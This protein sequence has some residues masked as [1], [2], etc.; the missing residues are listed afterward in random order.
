MPQVEADFEKLQAELPGADISITSQS[1]DNQARTCAC[2]HV[3][4]WQHA[5]ILYTM[6]GPSV[7]KLTCAC[8]AVTDQRSP[9]GF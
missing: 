8:E 4:S 2:T 3:L 9:G 6:L 1:R 5:S 7:F